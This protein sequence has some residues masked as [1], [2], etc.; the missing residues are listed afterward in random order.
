MMQISSLLYLSRCFH[1]FQSVKEASWVVVDLL[2]P[3]VPVV[4]HQHCFHICS[5]ARDWLWTHENGLGAIL[6]I[7]SS[8]FS[9]FTLHFLQAD[10]R[11]A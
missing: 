4:E 10:G 3:V 5:A 9:I 7:R 8:P 2:L 1:P 6:A 11:F